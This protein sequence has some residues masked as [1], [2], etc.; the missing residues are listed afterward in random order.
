MVGRPQK[1]SQALVTLA[2]GKSFRERWN[3]GCKANWQAYADKHGYDV[4][5]IEDPLDNSERAR[6]RSPAWQKLLLLRQDFLQSYERVVWIDSDILINPDSPDVAAGVPADKIGAVDEYSSPSPEIFR[7]TLRKLYR[8]WEENSIPF[9]RNERPADYY[10]KYGLPPVFDQVVQTG[11][12][13]LSPA[14]HREI[15]E[16]VYFS[17]EETKGPEW[18]YEMRPLS[19]ELLKAGCVH[20]LDPR[21]NVIWGSY[22]MHQ[23]P[24][25][26]NHPDHPRARECLEDVLSRVYFLHF[27]GGAQ[28]M[29]VDGTLS[30]RRMAVPEPSRQNEP[31]SSHDL[32]APVVLAIFNRPDTTAKVMEEIRRAKPSCLLVVADGPRSE[33][34]EDAD[35]CAEAREIAS[36]VDWDCRVLTNFAETNLGLRRR[37]QSG[38]D[39]VFDQV[40]EAIILE[41][42]CLPHP[43]FFRYCDDLLDRYRGDERIISISGSNFQLATGSSP[44][45][46]Y[47]SRYPQIWG[48]ATWRRAWRLYDADMHAWPSARESSWLSHKLGP[49]AASYWNYLFEKT[50][51]GMNTWDYQLLFTAWQNE[52]LSIVPSVNLVSNLGFR[53]DATHRT[54]GIGSEY[55][56][57]PTRAIDFP[58][59]H[60]ASLATDDAADEFIETTM[61][62]GNLTRLLRVVHSRAR[63]ARQ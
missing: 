22:K 30:P 13:V 8:Y 61:F 25:L 3:L 27:A 41:D 6:N 18:N 52:R 58:L 35:K 1:H 47:L 46:Y 12:M 10:G 16:S 43:T 45:S 31:A 53:S 38:L 26:M 36:Q 33:V 54:N 4:V 62:S 34:S 11:A 28:Q 37:L 14:H 21:F 57:L 5:C 24:F 60:P 44:A 49:T 23:Y 48:W 19:Y 9:V 2:I 32:R 39:W 59:A 17:Y 51:K 42:D 63:A 15:L 7:Q 55:A 50:Y 40:E 29:P 20:W 56:E